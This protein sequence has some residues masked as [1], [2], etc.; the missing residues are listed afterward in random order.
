MGEPYPFP[1]ARAFGGVQPAQQFAL[2]DDQLSAFGKQCRA[3]RR[4]SRSGFGAT[5]RTSRVRQLAQRR[6]IALLG[7]NVD[8]ELRAR[9]RHRRRRRPA[10]SDQQVNQGMG[11]AKPMMY[12]TIGSLV[13]YV[14]A[15]F[16]GPETK[17]KVMTADLEVIKAEIPA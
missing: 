17:G 3:H 7:Q 1:L 4:S 14:I 10:S 15:V 6:N 13:V 8:R 11:F 16:L 2:L 12:G 5:E 9:D